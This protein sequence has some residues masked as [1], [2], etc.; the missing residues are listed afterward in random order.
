MSR[1][2]PDM[3]EAQY[4]DKINKKYVNEYL[5]AFRFEKFE[6]FNTIS[7][8]RVISCH[9]EFHVR[10]LHFTQKFT[11]IYIPSVKNK[12]ISFGKFE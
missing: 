1:S 9:V 4:L 7:F 8:Q 5:N 12:Y 3:G 11:Q 2:I 6:Q 10:K